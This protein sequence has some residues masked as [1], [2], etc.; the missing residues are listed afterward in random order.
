MGHCYGNCW[1]RSAPF[2]NALDYCTLFNVSPEGRQLR[3]IR[4]DPRVQ[5]YCLTFCCPDHCIFYQWMSLAK[6]MVYRRFSFAQLM[7]AGQYHVSMV[8]D[9]P[10]AKASRLPEHSGGLMQPVHEGSN[11]IQCLA[12]NGMMQAM[13]C[14]SN[15]SLVRLCRLSLLSIIDS[16]FIAI[17]FQQKLLLA[18]L[19]YCPLFIVYSP[20]QMQSKQ[21]QWSCL[22]S[23]GCYTGAG[24]NYCTINQA[25]RHAWFNRCQYAQVHRF[26]PA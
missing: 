1:P 18:P 24:G 26:F 4:R 2:C 11:Y 7:P 9:A 16:Q 5:Q 23:R 19:S 14:K 8:H 22:H 20:A 10:H 25:C 21:H 12:R 13:Q 3:P 17:L 6:G 15:L